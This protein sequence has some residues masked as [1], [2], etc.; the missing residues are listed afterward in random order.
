MQREALIALQNLSSLLEVA[1]SPAPLLKVT[2]NNGDG[3]PFGL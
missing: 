3:P 1:D 2:I